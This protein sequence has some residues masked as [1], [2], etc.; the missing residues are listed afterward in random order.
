MKCDRR[1]GVRWAP[2]SAYEFAQLNSFIRSIAVT[3]SIVAALSLRILASPILSIQQQHAAAAAAAATRSI[4]TSLSLQREQFNK[5]KLKNMKKKEKAA[6][7]KKKGGV[8]KDKESNIAAG[9]EV[10]VSV[11]GMEEK[12][13]EYIDHMRTAFAQIQ[14]G[15]AVPTQLDDVLTNAHGQMVPL[16]AL[17]TVSARSAQVLVIQLYDPSL[18]KEVDK[19][20]RLYNNQLNPQLEPDGAVVVTFPKMTK[21]IRDGLVKQVVK[22]ADETRTHLRTIRQTYLH[23]LKNI[24]SSNDISQDLAKDLK[25]QIQTSH[26]VL[27]AKIKKLQ[28]EK[29]KEI[30][31]V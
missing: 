4:H 22:K 7:A 30:Q 28:E 17:G 16:K 26:D 24:Q 6:E 12:M 13:H 18:V 20:V 1:I 23:Q 3:I 5:D 31:Q 19:A 21:E 27:V 9:N 15:R 2:S 11:A 8:M 25:N 29:E 10:G 14:A